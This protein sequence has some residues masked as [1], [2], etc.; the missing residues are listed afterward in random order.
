MKDLKRAFQFCVLQVLLALTFVTMA[1]SI[2]EVK[3]EEKNLNPAVF[4]D[5]QELELFTYSFLALAAEAS[6][7]KVG[8]TGDRAN[9]IFLIKDDAIEENKIKLSTFSRLT[10]DEKNYLGQISLDSNECSLEIP[11]KELA[12]LVVDTKKI[13]NPE[14]VRICIAYGIAL[15]L[16]TNLAR[17]DSKTTWLQILAD[18]YAELWSKR[19]DN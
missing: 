10:D 13:I 7:K 3:F 4:H 9:I 12:I 14:H 8:P 15:I 18:L 17:P 6:G 5:D 16:D 2:E 19:K 1:S 11:N